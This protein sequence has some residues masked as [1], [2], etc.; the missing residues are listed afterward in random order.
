[1]TKLLEL[2]IAKMDSLSEKEQNSIAQIV[3]DEINS[4]RKWEELIARS[5][6]KLRKLADNAWAEHEAGHTEELDPDKL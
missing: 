3:L 2:A 1:M 4:E 5:P 6:E